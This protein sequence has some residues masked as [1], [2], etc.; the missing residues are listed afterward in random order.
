MTA[1]F[2]ANPSRICSRCGG[3]LEFLLGDLPTESPMVFSGVQRHCPSCDLTYYPA[4]S[5]EQVE[6]ISA[7]DVPPSDRVG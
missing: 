3:R 6:L 2:V 5:V 1:R 4:S 7:P